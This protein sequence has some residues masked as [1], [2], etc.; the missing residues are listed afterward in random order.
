MET[1]RKGDEGR[2]LCNGDGWTPSG[3]EGSSGKSCS[4]GAAGLPGWSL[5]GMVLPGGDGRTTVHDLVL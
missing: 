2:V 4:T 1:F 3:P 5:E